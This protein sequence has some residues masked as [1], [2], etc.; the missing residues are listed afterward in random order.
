VTTIKELDVCG[1]LDEMAKF[2]VRAMCVAIILGSVPALTILVDEPAAMA[3]PWSQDPPQPPQLSDEE[4][5]A[6]DAKRAGQPYDPGL[7]N[8]A[9]KKLE[10]GEKYAGD[11]NKQKR[12]RKR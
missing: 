8:S 10:T 5:A 2:L 3:T 4:R 1:I 12:G 6:I 11:R 9:Q 7:A